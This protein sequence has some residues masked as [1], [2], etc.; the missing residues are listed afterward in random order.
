M[1][2]TNFDAIFA[3]IEK[4]FVKLSKNAAKSAA[5]K[6]QNDIRE[7]ADKFIS[8]YYESYTPKIYR[9]KHA[10]YKLVQNY[11]KE[12]DNGKGL[13]IEFG[14]KYSPSK[15][16]HVHRSNSWWHQ[17]GKEWK[18]RLD[19][20]SKFNSSRQ[21][22][23]IPS[24]EWITSNFLDGIHPWAQTDAPSPDDKMQKFFDDELESLINTYMS[25]ALMESVASYF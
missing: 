10:L 3:Q 7:K 23:G 11:Y 17:S 24:P 8:E 25:D 20:E 5:N 13:T 22:N 2:D 14:I 1:A 9:R 19:T 15:M 4:D 12:R 21:D 6:A 16:G 18:S